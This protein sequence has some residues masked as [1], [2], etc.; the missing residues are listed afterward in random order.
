[1]SQK[2]YDW[3]D[4]V[5]E[6]LARDDSHMAVIFIFFGMISTLCSIL[7]FVYNIAGAMG[8]L[9]FSVFCYF[10]TTMFYVSAERRKTCDYI[11]K[12]FRRKLSVR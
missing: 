11:S 2:K 7:F 6:K 3:Y 4:P 1:M 5:L 9:S 10:L 12:G 8:F